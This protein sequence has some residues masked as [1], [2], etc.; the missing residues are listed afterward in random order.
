[1]RYSVVESSGESSKCESE[2][3]NCKVYKSKVKLKARSQNATQF[4]EQSL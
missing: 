2:M 4:I 3:L 1:M